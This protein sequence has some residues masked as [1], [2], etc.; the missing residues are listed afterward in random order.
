MKSRRQPSSEHRCV[1]DVEMASASMSWMGSMGARRSRIPSGM[2]ST[3]RELVWAHTDGLL[4]F[5]KTM[6][7][8]YKDTC[9]GGSA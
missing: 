1:V 5:V 7:Q 8:K 9:E 3:Q 4:W 6:A 2:T